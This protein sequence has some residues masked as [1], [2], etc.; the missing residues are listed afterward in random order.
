MTN[1]HE[2]PIGMSIQEGAAE[3][4]VSASTLYAMANQGRL[5]GCRRIG[6]RFVIHRQTFEEWLKNG[7][8]DRL[9]TSLD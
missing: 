1:D 4:G 7:M 6:K 3:I 2:Q 5:P 9:E 8:G